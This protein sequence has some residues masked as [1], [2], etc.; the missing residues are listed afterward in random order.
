MLTLRKTTSGLPRSCARADGEEDLVAACASRCSAEGYL[1]GVGIFGAAGAGVGAL[2]GLAIKKDR[3]VR[4]PVDR[5]RVG[6]RAVPAGAGVQ[7]SL[8]WGGR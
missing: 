1:V 5:V 3:W 6:I 7:V 8:R 4:V 2:T